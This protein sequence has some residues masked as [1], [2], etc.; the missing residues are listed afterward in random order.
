M[1]VKPL[2]DLLLDNLDVH[3]SF[4]DLKGVCFGLAISY[5]SIE[6]DTKQDKARNL[7]V[8]LEQR[9][10]VQDLI[11]WGKKNRPELAWDAPNPAGTMSTPTQ[12]DAALV[13][14]GVDALAALSGTSVAHPLIANFRADFETARTQISI[15]RNNKQAHDLLQELEMHVRPLEAHF[16]QVANDPTALDTLIEHLVGS[17][18]VIA[19]LGALAA[20]MFTGNEALLVQQLAGAGATLKSAM[21]KSE[22]AVLDQ[23]LWVV[24]RVLGRLPGRI[25]SLLVAAANLLLQSGILAHMQ[26]ARSA[27]VALH[28][29]ADLLASFSTSLDAIGRIRDRLATLRDRHDGWQLIDDDLKRIEASIAD[30]TPD[31]S[32]P[33][34]ELIRSWAD[35]SSQLKPL[36]DGEDAAVAALTGGLSLS[37]IETNLQSAITTDN[38]RGM[39]SLFTQF[40]TLARRR[41]YATDTQLL[42]VCNDLQDIGDSLDGLLKTLE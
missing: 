17:I 15:M 4:D 28:V 8:F 27:L 24:Q 9:N 41:F 19:R 39:R 1:P 6:G 42:E 23:P 20:S 22:Y 35:V 29:N 7:I 18:E 32:A 38:E 30:A 31:Q 11:A 12:Q 34:G 10:R 37:T 2:R 5:E 36:T 16:R 21:D 33:L 13:S 26:G 3:S 40:C 25:N 14:A